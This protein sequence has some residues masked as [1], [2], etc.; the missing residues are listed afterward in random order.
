[1]EGDAEVKEETTS[2]KEEGGS[3]FAST[4]VPTGRTK[5]RKPEQDR[6]ITGRAGKSREATSGMAADPSGGSQV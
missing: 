5:I 4:V 3:S 2:R 1:M 6:T